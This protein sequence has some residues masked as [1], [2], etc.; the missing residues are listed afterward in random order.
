MWPGYV[1]DLFKKAGY[2]RL[3]K[4][5]ELEYLEDKPKEFETAE[6]LRK[7]DFIM[8]SS[9]MFSKEEL[10]GASNL[11]LVQSIYSGYDPVRVE[12]LTQI[13]IP[14]ATGGGANAVGVAEQVILY[15]LALYKNLVK[16]HNN[17]IKGIRWPKGKDRDNRLFELYDKEVG[18]IGLGN[19][20]RQLA[21]ILQGFQAKVSYYDVTR[22]KDAERTLGVRYKQLEDLLKSSDIISLHVPGHLEGIIGERE[23]GL[24]KSSAI[25]INTTR[26]KTV[27]EQALYKALRDKKIAGAGL[28]VF[29]RESDIRKGEYIS[30]LFELENVVVSPHTAG[31]TYEAWFR[32]IDN[33]YINIVRVAEGKKPLWVVNKSVLTE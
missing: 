27:D 31:G 16:N 21:K 24:M 8:G 4:G 15:I 13:R 23:F 32:K 26:G 17:L 33:A 5:F 18:I 20:G 3:P 7:V 1:P 22:F 28:D 19:I 14:F 12:E 11:K 30:P 9:R 29:T 25:F 2:S 6:K 10:E